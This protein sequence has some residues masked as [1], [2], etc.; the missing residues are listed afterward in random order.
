MTGLHKYKKGINNM[1]NRYSEEQVTH[2]KKLRQEGISTRKIS[3]TTG[4]NRSTVLDI[5][6]GRTWSNIS[7]LRNNL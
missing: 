7:V 4:I 6:M 5:V 3:K 1:N 2:C